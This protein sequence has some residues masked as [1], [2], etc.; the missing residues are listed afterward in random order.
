ME[1]NVAGNTLTYIQTEGI[2]GRVNDYIAR[3]KTSIATIAKAI[4]YSRPTLSRYLSGKYD[5]DATELESRL[6]RYLKENNAEMIKF[7]ASPNN[8]GQLP[9][10]FESQD[11]KKILGVCQY[12]QDYHEMGIVI[13]KSG[14]GKTYTLKQYAKLSH[15]VFIECDVTMSPRDL[16][17][18]ISKALGIPPTY[19]TNHDRTNEIIDFL[20]AN[21]GYLII[22]DEADKLMSKYTDTK[23]HILRAIFD[24][25]SGKGDYP[26]CG[27]VIA[28][29]PALEIQI[30]SQLKQYATRTLARAELKGLNDK[31]IQEYLK[32]YEIEQD[33]LVELKARG[34]NQRTGCFRLLERT[35]RNVNRILSETE[36]NMITLKIIEQA[37]GM[38]ML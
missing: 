24:R 10:F 32:D 20:I 29:E 3:T 12:C 23:M 14:Y 1:V 21:P 13:G 8:A 4:E 35:M 36:G 27:I 33:A 5:S 2:A 17:K 31:E 30:K 18:E 15:A 6:E 9:K 19:G 37:S 16:L 26:T 7:P 25:S 38:M 22:V 34:L 28:G 11:A